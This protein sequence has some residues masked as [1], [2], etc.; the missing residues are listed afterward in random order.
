MAT[1]GEAVD[2]WYNEVD[3][4]GYDFSNPGWDYGTGHFTQVVWKGTTEVGCGVANG[5]VCCR[6]YPPGN[7]MGQF[8]ENVGDFI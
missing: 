3:D 1:T 7:Y 4:P 2:M 5:W 6:Y 8:P